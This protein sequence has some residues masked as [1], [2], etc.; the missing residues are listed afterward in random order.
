MDE[1]EVTET[2]A[3]TETEEKKD[4]LPKKIFQAFS[5]RRLIR[6]LG[7]LVVVLGCVH[8]YFLYSGKAPSVAN[9]KGTGQARRSY[10]GCHGSRRQGRH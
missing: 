3:K 1:T 4:S 2:E 8:A 7:V 5:G 10:A 6:L 9:K